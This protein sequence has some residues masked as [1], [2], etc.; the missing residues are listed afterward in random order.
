MIN[1]KRLVALS[2][3]TAMTTAAL[4]GGQASAQSLQDLQQ[5]QIE[6]Q[7]QIDAL[8]AAQ[9]EAEKGSDLKVKWKGAPELSSADGKFKMKIRGRA[10][11]D[12]GFVS[13]DDDNEDT[14]ATE[15]RTVRLGVEGVVMKDI[16]YKAEVDFAGNEVDLKDAYLQ[17]KGPVS[18]TFGQFKTPNSLQ[19]QTS[20][21]YTTFMERASFTDAF[22]LARQIGIGVGAGGDNWT[23]DAGIFRGANGSSD[24]DEGE[25]FAARATFGDKFD[26][27]A[28]HVGASYRYRKAGDDQDMF[29]YRQRPH[30]HLAGR[31]IATDRVADSD[32]MF[33]VELAGVFGPF[34]AQAEY[35]WLKANLDAPAPGQS[36]PKF[37]GGYIDLSWFI[38]GESRAYKGGSF[39]R[40]KVKNPV[41]EGGFGAW[42]IAARYDVVD[43]SDEGLF[44]GEQDT[45][46]IGVNWHLNDY[47]RFMFNYSKS[48]VENA[49]DVSDNGADGENSIDAVGVRFQ[50]DW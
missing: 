28:Y 8:K 44:G 29:R 15:F 9:K 35:A 24:E 27:G 2:A 47:T 25:T 43:L 42:Q 21:R 45:W 26:N 3:A 12:A 34:S 19:E 5:K 11:V 10:Y 4:L 41:F 31:Y 38:T 49:F 7:A 17:W 16:K 23:F 13:D 14:K 32:A 18:V 37:T 36:D 46:V 33:G 20:S 50:V 39:S 40:V 6:L 30:N 22:E 48:D 1:R